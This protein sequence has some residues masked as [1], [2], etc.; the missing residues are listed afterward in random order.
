MEKTTALILAGGTGC[1]MGSTVPKQ[2]LR[3][4]GIPV[5][6]HSIK[7][8][9][10]SD[11]ISD[12]VVV[13]HADY[14]ARME[15]VIKETQAKKV[16]KLV[17]GGETRQKSS[18]IGLK[19]CSRDTKYVLIHDSARPFVCMSMVGSLLKAAKLAGSAGPV[20]DISD[21]VVETRGG[22]IS[23]ILERDTLGRMQTPQA[24]RYRVIVE[25]HEKA[26]VFGLTS[27]SD[28]CG[29]VIKTGGKVSIV[30]GN[31]ENLKITSAADMEL[32]EL[33]FLRKM[34]TSA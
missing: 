2:F 11:E 27:A 25:A 29:L 14:I 19:N 7:A 22:F 5:V 17:V 16:R 6:S 23:G 15:S 20:T 1:R 32:A 30:R 8:F 34:R 10:I 26:L 24:F 18:F 3:L 4:G 31:E 21:T 28:D 12:I 33:I 13:C 9:E